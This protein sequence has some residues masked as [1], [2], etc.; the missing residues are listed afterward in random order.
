MGVERIPASNKP[1]K[2]NAPVGDDDDIRPGPDELED[3]PG[4]DSN[5]ESLVFLLTW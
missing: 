3:L 2:E 5:G 1:V 4:V